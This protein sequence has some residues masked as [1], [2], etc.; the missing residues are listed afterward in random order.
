MVKSSVSDVNQNLQR[1]ILSIMEA[2]LKK[3]L[4]LRIK[5]VFSKRLKLIKIKINLN[6]VLQFRQI[7]E[8][9]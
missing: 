7:N 4:A 5:K 2:S 6:L 8:V 3:Y 9:M 1:T